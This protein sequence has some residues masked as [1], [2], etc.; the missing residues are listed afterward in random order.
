MGVGI[1]SAHIYSYYLCASILLSHSSLLGPMTYPQAGGAIYC[2]ALLANE[3]AALR[4][5]D[6]TSSG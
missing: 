3:E 5:G 2:P 1:N 4:N 6:P